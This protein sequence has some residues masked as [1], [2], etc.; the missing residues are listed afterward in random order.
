[1]SM[2]SDLEFGHKIDGLHSAAFRECFPG[3]RFHGQGQTGAEFHA[4]LHSENR[5]FSNSDY[6]YQGDL[7]FFHLTR[8]D[9]LFSILNARA[10]RL[11]NLHSSNDEE[12]YGYAG[13]VL[14]LTPGRIEMAKR[15]F[16][17]LSCCPLNELYNKHIWEKYGGGFSRAA[18]FF[19]IEN[20][21]QDWD[22][23]HIAQVKYAAAEP[24]KTYG[25]RVREIETKYGVTIDCDLSQLIGFHKGGGWSEEKEVRISTYFPYRDLEQYWKYASLDYRQELGRNRSTYYIELPIWIDN[26]STWLKSPGRP[27][28]DRTR[29]LP[30]GYYDTRPKIKLKKILI[31]INSGLSMQ[32]YDRLCSDL[33]D[34]TRYKL[35]YEVEVDLNMF[36]F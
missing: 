3:L 2:E 18:L 6:Y 16:F 10:F 30:A 36:G 4:Y 17:T 34:V 5:N 13:K 1:M 21:P 20:K 27:D 11:Y 14:G 33:V 23:F 28:L 26:D 25:E 24:F 8:I 9:S 29:I 7:E 12:E 22:N 15:Y 35:G 19:S 31:G 32:E